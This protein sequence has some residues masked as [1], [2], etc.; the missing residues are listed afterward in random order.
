MN[1]IKSLISSWL[2]GEESPVR[3]DLNAAQQANVPSRPRPRGHMPFT[4]LETTTPS[5]PALPS[6]QAKAKGHI[7]R[8]LNEHDNIEQDPIEV[9]ASLVL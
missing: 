6:R 2:P 7:G 3:I 8:F 1:A 4:R 9:V 5:K